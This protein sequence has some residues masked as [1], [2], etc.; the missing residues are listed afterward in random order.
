MGWMAWTVPSAIFFACIAS[1][2]V[3]MT[4][5]ELVR[6][7]VPRRGWLPMITTRGDRFFIALLT[8]A[9][10]H[11]GWLAVSDLPVVVASACS[12]ILGLLIL[13]FG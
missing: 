10:V 1:A 6:P 9:Y 11:A 4:V 8:S 13:R 7:G 5:F 2:L 12:L 3:A